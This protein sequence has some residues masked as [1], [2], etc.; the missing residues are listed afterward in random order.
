MSLTLRVKK[1]LNSQIIGSGGT[2][3]Y[4]VSFRARLLAGG[5]HTIHV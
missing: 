5:D 1:K 2:G 4:A 3:G